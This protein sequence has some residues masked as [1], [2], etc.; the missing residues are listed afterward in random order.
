[1]ERTFRIERLE[2]LEQRYS[3]ELDEAIPRAA[4]VSPLEVQGYPRGVYRGQRDLMVTS[5]I[6]LPETI[7]ELYLHAGE[8]GLA[9][10]TIERLIEQYGKNREVLL[11]GLGYSDAQR[12]ALA[13]ISAALLV[14]VAMIP[15]LG[16]MPANESYC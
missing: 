1:M 6:E 3:V 13:E 8:E 11:V 16:L 9:S 5:G 12:K 15:Y 4:I 7:K 2:A 10:S 14:P